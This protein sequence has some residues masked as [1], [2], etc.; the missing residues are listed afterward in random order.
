MRTTTEEPVVSALVLARAEI[1]PTGVAAA[2]PCLEGISASRL[3]AL[4]G[5]QV[6]RVV[7]HLWRRRVLAERRIDIAHCIVL[8]LDEL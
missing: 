3:V 7:G 8:L 4:H 6:E 1:E 2:R 5:R